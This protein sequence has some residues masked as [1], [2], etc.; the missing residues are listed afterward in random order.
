MATLD[1]ALDEAVEDVLARF[2]IEPLSTLYNPRTCPERYLPF[3]RDYL[4]ARTWTDLLG[5][6]YQ[7]V[8]LQNAWIYH[9]YHGLA[10]VF[11]QFS[12][13][14]GIEFRLDSTA[15]ADGRL[16]EVNVVITSS[17]S[18][19]VNEWARETVESLLA[20]PFADNVLT[21]GAPEQVTGLSLSV[22]G[23]T[24]TATWDEPEDNNDTITGYDVEY[25]ETG[26]TDWDDASH[27]G[28]GR[29]ATIS[30]LMA[31]EEYQV[32]VRAVNSTGNGEYSTPAPAAIGITAPG[33]PSVALETLGTTITVTI[34][35]PTST[36]N[37]AIEFYRVEYRVDGTTT[38]T[39]ETSETLTHT[40]FSL[41][42]GETYE[43][44]ATAYNGVDGTPSAIETI[45][46]ASSPPAA[47]GM[48]MLSA[49]GTTITATWD[50]P[51]SDLALTGYDV[52]YKLTTATDYTPVTHT[53]LTREAM[54]YNL[55]PGSAYDVQ[56]RGIS[57]AGDGVWA[58]EQVTVPAIEPSAP[59]VSLSVSGSSLEVTVTDGAT[60]GSAILDRTVEW[61]TGSANWSTR[62][63]TGTTTTL[64]D[65]SRGHTYDVRART[66]NAMGSSPYS[67][68]E[69][70]VIPEVRPGAPARVCV[71]RG[72]SG[73]PAISW[74]PPS[75]PGGIITGYR[76]TWNSGPLGIATMTVN[77]G[78]GAR[79]YT[80]GTGPAG[81]Y[82]VRVAARNSAGLG[83]TRHVDHNTDGPGTTCNP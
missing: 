27:T 5:V 76:V 45:T 41:T 62:T 31:G 24:I 20:F 81:T 61:R 67:D 80:V 37:R 30:S 33:A 70:E 25:Q 18:P 4:E 15:D 75:S 65:L 23:T 57:A 42:P 43:V 56:V 66:R 21:L 9:R 35:A 7:R 51:T 11:A 1:T 54:I 10:F 83:P 53:T 47:P 38:W 6:A 69:M 32:R 72:S 74:N 17:H 78:S 16:F 59:T 3:L 49:L 63:I 28:T 46:I 36:G 26:A 22:S 50:E 82:G 2:N 58:S 8:S 40:I 73:G 19:A 48:L 39:E 14:T 44:Q 55:A 29:T 34:T 79:S 52:Q 71:T 68:T 77:L 60:G 12:R 13:D 64:T